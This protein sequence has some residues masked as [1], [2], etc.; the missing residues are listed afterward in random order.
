MIQWLKTLWTSCCKCTHVGLAHRTHS[1]SPLVG[2]GVCIKYFIRTEF[3]LNRFSPTNVL[4]PYTYT[5]SKKNRVITS[6]LLFSV[7]FQ[8]FPLSFDIKSFSA[9]SQTSHLRCSRATNKGQV[10]TCRMGRV[11]QHGGTGEKGHAYW[12]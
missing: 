1:I 8:L 10:V 7:L 4:I 11:T 9:G 12:H 2:M 5:I 6:S 3:A